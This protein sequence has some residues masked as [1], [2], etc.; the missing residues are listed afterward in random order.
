MLPVA[1]SA[2]DVHALELASALFAVHFLSPQRACVFAY[3]AGIDPAFI[4]I[5]ALFG[6]NLGKFG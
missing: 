6:W 3:Q 1:Q 2:Y 4:D 5:Y